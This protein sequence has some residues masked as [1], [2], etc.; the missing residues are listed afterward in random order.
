MYLGQK[1]RAK[2]LKE[3]DRNTS[4][5]HATMT[6]RRRRN[7]IFRLEKD[8][9]TWGE[10]NESIEEEV[11]EYYSKLFQSSGLQDC[12]KI[13]DGILKTISDQ[14]NKKLIKP[15]NTTEIRRAVFPMHLDKGH[16]LDRIFPL[17]FKKLWKII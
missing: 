15:V 10:T 17:F 13:L 2:W 9:G 14:M 8:N 6:S 4:Y 12:S 3:G 11:C 7:R 1:S 5:F 16:G